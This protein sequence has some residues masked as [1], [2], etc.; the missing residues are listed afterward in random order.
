M[1]GKRLDVRPRSLSNQVIV[2]RASDLSGPLDSDTV[3]LVDG[4][5]DMGSTQIKVPEGGL[6]IQG[7][8]FGVSKLSS[9]EAAYSMFVVDPAGTYSGDLFLDSIEFEVTGTGSQVWDLDNAENG[10]A[11]ECTTVNFLNCK[12]LGELANYRQGLWSNVALIRCVDGVTCSGPWA[13][14]F[15]AT[16]AII[17]SAGVDFT[18][19]LFK[20]GPGLVMSGR[21]LT[22]MNVEQIADIGTFCDFAPANIANNGRFQV[23]GLSINPNANGFPNMPSSSVKARFSNCD[24]VRN[25][26]IGGQWSITTEVETVIAAANTPV[27]VAGVTTYVDENWFG[28]TTDNAFI[29]E[30]SD[31]VGVTI[32]CNLSFSGGN[33]DQINVILRHWVDSSSSWVDLAESGPFTLNNAGRAENIGLHA[34]CDYNQNDRLEV[35]V[36]NQTDTD[37]VTAKLGGIVSINERSS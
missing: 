1:N 6:V 23:R 4:Q 13:G 31:E 22:D 7:L 15:R 18:G 25:T 35:W 20:A 9:S 3:Y 32:F 5:I 2:K 16:T 36:E 26:Y 37:N 21:F 17:V 34:F 24:G 8:G 28:H 19:T 14:G 12:L 29:Y 27:K 10:H 33:A 11:V 30:G